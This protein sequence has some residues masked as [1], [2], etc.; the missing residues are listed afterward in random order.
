MFR[1]QRT[2][3]FGVLLVTLLGIAVVAW[4]SLLPAGRALASTSQISI[5]QDD[6]RIATDPAGTFQ[7]LR[8]LGAQY[9]RVLVR[10][11]SVA[12][13]AGSYRRPSHFN[14]L[15]P[16]AYPARN[17]APWD[18]V[19]RAAQ[20]ANIGLIFDLAGGAPLWATGPGAPKDKAYPNWEPS[21]SQYGQFVHAIA[22][23][24]SGNYNP[25]TNKLA[26]GDAGDL[27]RVSSWSIWNEP[28]YGPSLAPQGLPGNLTIDHAP[29]MY[30]GLVQAAWGA[31]QGTGHGRDRILFGEV[32]PR[33]EAFWGVFSGMMPLVFIR[34]LYCLD[35]SYRPLRGNAARLRGCPTTA[36]GTRAFRGANPGLFQASG[37]ADH[38]YMRWYPPN[39]EQN[40]D[41]ANHL[42]TGD[43]STLGV[44][45][46][47]TRALDRAQGTYGAHP[48]M[49]VYNTEFG[50]ITTPPKHNSQ[51]EPGGHRYPWAS[52]TTAAYYINWAE[53]LSW[54]NPRLGSY[55]Q[56]LL[57]DPLP[58]LASND[59]GG[60]ASGLINYGPR[61]IPKA[62]YY[63]WRF[64]LYLP[65]ISSRRGRSLE[66]W[67]CIRPAH[68]AMLD[69]PGPQTAA[70]QFAPGSSKTF[71]TVKTVTVS[72]P[73][74]CYF[75]TRVTFPGTGNVRLMWQYPAGDP[76]LGS[77]G[78]NQGAIFS[79][80][81]AITLR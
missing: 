75:D 58:G 14:A 22:T 64:P 11:Q 81:V 29:Q 65:V 72:S 78:A 37:F 54:R 24:Y 10:W 62:T 47:L 57:Y 51:L 70:I 63:A 79:R 44:I 15:D 55:E 4:L 69:T 27:P 66:V 53:Y 31:F 73:D 52:Q 13:S 74:N 35:S 42:H 26:P 56:Y 39:R 48:H 34:S 61:Q 3:L 59:W 23:R 46:Q 1:V 17:W 71:T 12:P 36:A 32:A 16:A 33:G 20:K 45:G 38:P 76:V 49:P 8:M 68:Y 6:P 41:P 18:G 19:V 67:G 21:A 60:F 50:Y 5:M 43:Y 40:P 7:K 25:V 80:N 9:V 77:F 28:D 2:S 30:R